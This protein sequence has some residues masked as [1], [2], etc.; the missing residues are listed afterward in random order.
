MTMGW[1]ELVGPGISGYGCALL[2]YIL[3]A[4][5]LTESIGGCPNWVYLKIGHDTISSFFLYESIRVF[6]EIF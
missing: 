4:R 3:V 1:T 5:T 2:G 6:G